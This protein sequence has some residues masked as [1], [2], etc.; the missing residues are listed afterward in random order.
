M[1]LMDSEVLKVR[2]YNNFWNKVVDRQNCD[3][4]D[5]LVLAMR[6]N[7]HWLSVRSTGIAAHVT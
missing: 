1:Q 3:P 5:W 7:A 4:S 6:E 2:Q